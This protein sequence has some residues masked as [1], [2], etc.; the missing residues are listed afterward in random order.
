LGAGPPSSSSG[1]FLKRPLDRCF[2]GPSVE[3]LSTEPSF[4][5]AR[6]PLSSHVVVVC[7]LSAQNAVVSLS[8]PCLSSKLDGR[9]AF[10]RTGLLPQ[11]TPPPPRRHPIPGLVQ[12]G[13]WSW[14]KFSVPVADFRFALPSSQCLLPLNR[15]DPFTSPPPH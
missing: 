1:F 8:R 11:T 10:N 12:L 15:P 14:R 13:V 4:F 5:Q 7:R 9:S 3:S 6:A 2:F